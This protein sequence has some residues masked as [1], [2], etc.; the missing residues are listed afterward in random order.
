MKSLNWRRSWQCHH[1][2]EYNDITEK[3]ALALISEEAS[4]VAKEAS[5]SIRFGLNSPS[6]SDDIS[7]KKKLL[8]EIGDF[9]AAIQYAL[10]RNII[11]DEDIEYINKV[12]TEKLN[13]LLDPESKDNLGR[14]LAP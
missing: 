8:N 13:K 7:A 1:Y 9:L 10:K 2:H 6:N 4:E 3:Y 5:K 14:R 11:T 12:E